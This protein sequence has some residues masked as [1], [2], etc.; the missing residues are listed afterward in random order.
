MACVDWRSESSL[1]G[2]QLIFVCSF[3]ADKLGEHILRYIVKKSDELKFRDIMS[4][5]C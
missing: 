1:V 5:V 3:K 2:K 4:M